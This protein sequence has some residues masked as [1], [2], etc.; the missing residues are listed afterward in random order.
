MHNHSSAILLL[1]HGARHD[2]YLNP[3]QSIRQAILRLQPTCCVSIAFLDLTQPSFAKAVSALYGQG[4][5]HIRV[6][7]LFFA[8]GHHVLTTIP[9]LIERAR[10]I[11]PDLR[12]HVLPIAG[13]DDNVIQSL[14]QFAL[15]GS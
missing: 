1:S 2:A 3:F 6:A 11:H 9:Q 12:I 15:Q 8:P 14:A 4:L 13:T 5:R 7:P 10:L